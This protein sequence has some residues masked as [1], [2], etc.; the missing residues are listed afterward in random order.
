MYKVNS[1]VVERD[2]SA[3]IKSLEVFVVSWSSLGIVSGIAGIMTDPGLSNLKCIWK[4]RSELKTPASW[5]SGTV[6][7]EIDLCSDVGVDSQAFVSYSTKLLLS[8]SGEMINNI[9]WSHFPRGWS[10][11]LIVTVRDNCIWMWRISV[12][13]KTLIAKEVFCLLIP[14]HKPNPRGVPLSAIRSP[15]TGSLIT[16]RFDSRVLEVDIFLSLWLCQWWLWLAKIHSKTI[17]NSHYTCSVPVN[18]RYY[19]IYIFERSLKL[20]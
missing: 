15:T 7:A 16:T 12:F 1:N 14:K 3:S 9:F 17:Y 18:P 19:I 5:R 4:K 8:E 10:M 13:W 6:R 11:R 2:L 20:Y